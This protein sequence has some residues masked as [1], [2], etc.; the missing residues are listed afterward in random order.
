[1]RDTSLITSYMS[2]APFDIGY[3]DY[4]HMVGIFKC[5]YTSQFMHFNVISYIIMY[6]YY[7]MAMY[8]YVPVH[9]VHMLI[10]APYS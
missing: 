9:C 7:Q 6:V 2:V 3:V 4:I 8:V 1:M 10:M 5:V